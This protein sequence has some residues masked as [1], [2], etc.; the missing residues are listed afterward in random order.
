MGRG[1]NILISVYWLLTAGLFAL[2]TIAVFK[3][4]P[5]ERTMGG[6]QKIFYL[7]LPVAIFTFVACSTCFVGC[8]GYL[9]QRRTWWDDLASAGAR[10]SVQFCAVVLL[11]GMIWGKSAWGQWWTWSPRLTFS[12]ILFLLYVVYLMLRASVE[13]RQRKAVVSAVYGIITFL[14][15]P[16]VYL[17]TRLMPADIHP[18]S[19][20]LDPRMKLTLAL[21]FVPVTLLGLGMLVLRY[22]LNRRGSLALAVERGFPVVGISSQEEMRLSMLTE[23]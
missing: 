21:F 1:R 20:G 9:W 13:S 16:M 3:W 14:D 10:V 7:H 6:I 15:V 18:A 22:Q 17:S 8:V 19:I 5:T 23:I 11:T 12:L 4:T 2:A